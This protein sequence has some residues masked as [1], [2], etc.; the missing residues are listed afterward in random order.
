MI[1]AE[2]YET[3]EDRYNV[4]QKYCNKHHGCKGCPLNDN[5]LSDC[6]FSWLAVKAEEQF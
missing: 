1:N 6:M 4:F 2:K 5:K 3:P